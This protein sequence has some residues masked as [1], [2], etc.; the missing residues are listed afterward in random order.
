MELKRE[1]G[2]IR[3]HYR[4]HQKQA[5]ESVVWF[6]FLPLG[7]DPENN[8]I[9]DDVYDEGT[10]GT[11]GRKYRP[12]IIVPVLM[13]TETE[14]Q[15]RSI[16]EGRQPVQLTNIIASMEDFRVAGITAPHEYRPHLNDMFLYDGRYF[17]VS[18]YRVRGRAGRDDVMII[19]EGIEVYI[20]EELPNDPGPNSYGIQDLPWPATLPQL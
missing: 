10:P 4:W 19:V 8:S 1:L 9:Y 16:P 20:N 7:T 2:L 15:K 6:Q 13:V 17:S 3:R 5:G 11:G 18:T 12:G 14:D